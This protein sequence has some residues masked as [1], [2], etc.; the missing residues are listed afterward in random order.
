MV[1]H[2]QILQLTIEQDLFLRSV[3][4]APIINDLVVTNS[5]GPGILLW[6]GGA[7]GQDWWTS[8]NGASGADFREFHPQVTILRSPR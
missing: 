3:N 4:W 8:D 6:K 1:S 7:M 2:L 5:T